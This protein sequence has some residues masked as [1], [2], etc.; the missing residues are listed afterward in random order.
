M[1]GHHE[2]LPPQRRRLNSKLSFLFLSQF[3]PR[4]IIVSLT[5]GGFL[6]NKK[7][8]QR[9]NKMFVWDLVK[10]FFLNEF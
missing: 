1:E 9:E 3:L 10:S 2:Y 5:H 4:T 6:L 8:R 7:M